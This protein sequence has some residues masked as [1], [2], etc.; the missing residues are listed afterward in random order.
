MIRGC[1]DRMSIGWCFT[2][3]VG[4]AAPTASANRSMQISMI[5]AMSWP[6]ISLCTENSA[7]L[8]CSR[9]TA[10]ARRLRRD[11]GG[12]GREEGEKG[13]GGG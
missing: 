3:P 13:G 6:F 12:K 8:S 4:L 1:I 11:R 5:L 2:L 10:I 9:L 7:M